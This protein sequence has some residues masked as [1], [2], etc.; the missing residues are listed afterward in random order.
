MTSASV[1]TTLIAMIPLAYLLGSIPFGLLIARRHGVDP[2]QAGSGNIGAS[3]VGRLLGRKFFFVVF[4]LDMGKSL[5]PMLLASAMAHQVAFAVRGPAIYWL[6]LAVGLAAVFG[7]LFSVFLNFKGGKGVATGAGFLL[8][9]VPFYTLPALGA[10]GVFIIAFRLTR[11]ISVGSICATGSIILLY[12]GLAFALHWDP[13]GRQ[14][15]LM[16]TTV[17]LFLLI[18]Y[19]HRTNI[20]RLMNGTENKF[21]KRGSE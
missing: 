18:L 9:L 10:V 16:L 1:Q 13:F 8:G 12:L 14:Y 4:L 11:T 3:N 2:R 15:P 5:L 7:H 17:L 19:T 21:V 20:V 6:W